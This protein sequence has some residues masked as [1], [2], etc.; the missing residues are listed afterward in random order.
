[1]LSR[2]NDQTKPS[3]KLYVYSGHDVTLVNVMRALDII[4]QTSRKP[5]YSS[6][7]HFELHQNPNIADDFEVKV[8][9]RSLDEFKSRLFSINTEFVNDIYL[10]IFYSISSEA[11]LQQINIPNCDSP[12]SLTKFEEAV[13]PIVIRDYNQTCSI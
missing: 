12:C 1:M 3:R 13:Q 2:R 4:E 7:L 10:Q 6:A 9:S 5:D 11:D 8:R